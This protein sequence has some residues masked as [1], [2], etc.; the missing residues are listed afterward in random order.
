MIWYLIQK[1]KCGVQREVQPEIVPVS[2]LNVQA[3]TLDDEGDEFSFVSGL[4]QVQAY[5]VSQLA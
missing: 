1:S 3:P 5:F 4:L 2:G